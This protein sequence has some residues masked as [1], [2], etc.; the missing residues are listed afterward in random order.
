MPTR[1]KKS[2]LACAFALP[3]LAAGLAGCNP[4]DQKNVTQDAKNLASSSG[5]ALTNASLAGKVNGVLSLWKGVDMS[6]FHVQAQD[7]V[8]TLEGHVRDAAEKKRV[9][10]VAH[11]IRGVNKVID[12]LT[13]ETKTPT[14]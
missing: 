2:L 7:G 10:F 3:A 13:I 9:A 14:K 4:Q 11:Q 12:N 1:R 8:I 6:S 5:E